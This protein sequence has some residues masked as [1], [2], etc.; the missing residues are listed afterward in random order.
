M[1]R[2][3]QRNWIAL[4][5]FIGLGLML[6]T[7]QVLYDFGANLFY[8]LPLVVLFALVAGVSLVAGIAS[9]GDLSSMDLAQIQAWNLPLLAIPFTEH[10]A[11][12]WVLFFLAGFSLHLYILHHHPVQQLQRSIGEAWEKFPH[13][14]VVACSVAMILI[15]LVWLQAAWVTEDAYISFRSIDNWI[16]GYGPR[17]NPAERVQTYTHPLWMLVMTGISFCTQEHFYSSV[18]ASLVLSGGAFILLLKNHKFGSLSFLL[19]SLAAIASK[20]LVDFTTSGLENCLSFFLAALFLNTWFNKREGKY[21]LVLLT[22]LAALSV[23]NR[24]DTL[25][26]FLPA[27]LYYLW[28][29]TPRKLISHLLWMQTGLLPFY[30]WTLFSLL[31]YGFPFP[32]TAYA[33]LA[34]GI[35]SIEFF[36]QG[37]QYYLDSVSRDPVTLMLL[38]SMLVLAVKAGKWNIWAPA[39]G[40]FLYL[41]Y[42]LKIG[43]DFMSGRFFSVPVFISIGLITHISI[44]KYV[45][46]AFLSSLVILSFFNVHAPIRYFEIPQLADT[47]ISATGISD[48]RY[49]FHKKM[50]LTNY[51]RL[52]HVEPPHYWI[53]DGRNLYR[54]RSD[55]V[56]VMHIGTVG[57]IS[58]YAGPS[59]HIVDFLTDPVLARMP[60][61]AGANWRVGH[62]YRPIPPGY[63]ETIETGINQIE[64]PGLQ[65]YYNLMQIVVAGDIWDTERLKIVVKMNLGYYNHLL[66]TAEEVAEWQ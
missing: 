14:Q 41:L 61:P 53:Q 36:Q 20:S 21:K 28:F 58:Y 13:W 29:L 52:N 25:L 33:K 40:V 45:Y 37:V 38:F 17:Y 12:A 43:G 51:P 31:Y 19:I 55:T 27:L 35:S 4:I 32:N 2:S 15:P 1:L 44:K 56:V 16:Q 65:E 10:H 24:H 22:F 8:S 11:A 26:L 60:M 57:L 30:C 9:K 66:P 7:H 39:L 23:V 5:P 64:H 59:Y 62:Y 47:E 49:Y 54:Q 50:S 3:L 46:Y 48:E 42:T 63:L 34:T 18:A 6:I